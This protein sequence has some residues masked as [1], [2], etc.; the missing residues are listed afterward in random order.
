MHPRLRT[1]GEPTRLV[2]G[3][4]NAFLI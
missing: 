4:G 3:G 1:S 2:R